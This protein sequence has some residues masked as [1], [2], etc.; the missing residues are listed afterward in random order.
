M[1]GMSHRIIQ[2]QSNSTTFSPTSLGYD[3]FPTIFPRFFAQTT[4]TTLGDHG[5]EGREDHGSESL[6]VLGD[7]VEAAW[8]KGLGVPW[9]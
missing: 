8:W 6:Q 4:G 3:H 7:E 2:P 5:E 1:K 9:G